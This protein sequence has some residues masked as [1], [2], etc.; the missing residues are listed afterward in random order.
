MYTNL[1]IYEDY[2]D[3]KFKGSSYEATEDLAISLLKSFCGNFPT[4]KKYNELDEETQI[5]VKKAI[6]WQV[7]YIDDNRAFF[8]NEE[9]QVTRVAIGRYSKT[10]DTPK[11]VITEKCNDNAISFMIDSGLCVFGVNVDNGCGCIDL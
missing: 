11:N 7:K 6:L 1:K 8:Y 10:I 4:L 2:F 3:K 9:Q 5:T